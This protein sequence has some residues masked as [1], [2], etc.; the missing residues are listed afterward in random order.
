MDDYSDKKS[1][2]IIDKIPVKRGIWKYID[3]IDIKNE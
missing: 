1:F 2:L 3:K